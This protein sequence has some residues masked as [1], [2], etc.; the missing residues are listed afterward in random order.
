MRKYGLFILFF[1]LF[2]IVFSFRGYAEPVIS[3]SWESPT[4]PATYSLGEN[5]IFNVTVCD[6]GGISKIDT[7]LFEWS[8]EPSITVT[9]YVNHN[10][11][12]LNF[13]T[14]KTDLS[15]NETG[16][17]FKWY[18]NNTLNESAT[19]LKGSY[20]INK[21]STSV[22]L[23]LNGTEGNKNYGI[24]VIAI[25]TAQLNVSG[26][27]IYLNSTSPD[28]LSI[29][30]DTSFVSNLTTLNS[31]GMFNLT[32]YWNGDENYSSSNQTYF[33]NVTPFWINNKT[34]INSSSIYSPDQVYQFN[35]TWVGN[36][37]NVI[38]ESDFNDTLVNYTTNNTSSSYW[39]NFTDLPAGPYTYRWYATDNNSNT[40]E[41]N[42]WNYI[43]LP[44]PVSLSWTSPSSWSF[45]VG[46]SATIICSANDS[47]VNL[48]LIV[49]TLTFYSNPSLGSVSSGSISPSFEKSYFSNCD[50]SSSNYSANSIT[51]TLSFT[52]SSSTLGGTPSPSFT[53]AIQN[54]PSKVSVNAGEST[55]AS[56]NVRN[57][58][59]FNMTVSITLKN[60]SS[61]WYSLSRNDINIKSTNGTESITIT[62][63]IPAS[64]EV[65]NYTV[66][67]NITGKSSGGI[68]KTAETT[69]TLNVN[70]SQIVPQQTNET[71]TEEASNV[72]TAVEGETNQTAGPTGLISIRP[73]DFRNIVLFFGLI[74]I[75][76]IFIFRDK[77]TYT[78]TRGRS[79]KGSLPKI[80]VP[81]VEVR[82]KLHKIS[83]IR[84]R[85]NLIRKRKK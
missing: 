38:F 46:S 40:V 70:P 44:I 5:Y 51:N 52:T 56:F 26:K 15:A 45:T 32:A 62:F 7:V 49:D 71:E 35:I 37:S 28:W 22:M 65:K 75:G 2:L 47:A 25:F 12:C 42:Q 21:A 43:I 81:K 84:L 9:E 67:V 83:N 74:A 18:A 24:N 55:T 14:T 58:W 54:L 39:I 53:F 57:T 31:S 3:D 79:G 48:T 69:M 29:S 16:W 64:A 36:L 76:L 10:S 23:W 50:V 85:I 63:N 30:N 20:T 78:F 61:D 59:Q 4:D 68:I 33:F 41:T 8:G 73:E 82:S 11:T 1:A 72:T 27:T 6:A 66:R 13:T 17:N 19:P 80:S 34:S 77:I 60:I